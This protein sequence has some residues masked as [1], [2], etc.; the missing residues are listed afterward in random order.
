MRSPAMAAVVLHWKPTWSVT[1]LCVCTCDI[2][3]RGAVGGREL[4][5]LSSG[6]ATSGT[7]GSQSSTVF[8]QMGSQWLCLL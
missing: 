3:A 1:S 7:G 4:S 6:T 8:S 2:P 5:F